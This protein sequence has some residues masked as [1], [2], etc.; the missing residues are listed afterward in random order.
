MRVGSLTLPTIAPPNVDALLDPITAIVLQC[1]MLISAF[2]EP[3]RDALAPVG[4]DTGSSTNTQASDDTNASPAMA[5]VK[6]E[7]HL[8]SIDMICEVLQ[9]QSSVI[10]G[11]SD[12][13]SP[14]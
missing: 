10:A 2:L 13:A 3:P 5:V 1:P 6:T 12:V 7:E 11:N 14:S 4:K 9:G 8:C